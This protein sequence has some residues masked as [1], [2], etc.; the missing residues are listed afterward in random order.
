MVHAGC[1]FVAG[2]HLSRAQMSG[3]FESVQWNACVNRLDIGLYS[4]PKQF[5]GNGVRTHA[6]SKGKIPSTGKF[7]LKGR[8][9]PRCCIKLDSEPNTLPMSYSSPCSKTDQ[10][11]AQKLINNLLRNSSPTCSEATT[12]HRFLSWLTGTQITHSSTSR[13]PLLIIKCSFR[14]FICIPLNWFMILHINVQKHTHCSLYQN[15]VPWVPRAPIHTHL[16]THT[17]YV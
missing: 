7:L 3:S 13:I 16:P 9:N 11:L 10:H 14:Y 5:L 12:C 8:S 15:T 6:Y 2:I 1:A 17:Y 4:H